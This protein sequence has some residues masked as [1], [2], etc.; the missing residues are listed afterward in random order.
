[1][2]PNFNTNQNTSQIQT[3]QFI[4]TDVNSGKCYVPL[5]IG[6]DYD[7]IVLG[8]CSGNN[9]KYQWEDGFIKHINSGRYL[10]TWNNND[11]PQENEGILLTEMND[12]DRAE[13][14]QFDFEQSNTDNNL[15]NAKIIHR[16]SGKCVLPKIGLDGQVL[17]SVK[18]C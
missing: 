4:W 17:L 2:I 13:K 14:R 11:L 3:I 1:M 8:D 12:I 7:K 5:K 10:Q 6:K 15:L 18:N 16:P 9:A